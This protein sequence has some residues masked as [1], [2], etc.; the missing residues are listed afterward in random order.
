MKDSAV[1]LQKRLAQERDE[2]DDR[3]ERTLH[4]YKVT[5]RAE[6]EPTEAR[7]FLKVS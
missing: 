3:D 4:M 6:P 2:R 5:R 7:C 1:L